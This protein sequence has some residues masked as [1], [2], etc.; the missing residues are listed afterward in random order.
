MYGVAVGKSKSAKGKPAGEGMLSVFDSLDVPAFA[1]GKGGK[2]IYANSALE[3]KLK[4]GKAA[5]GKNVADVFPFPAGAHLAEACHDALSDGKGHTAGAEKWVDSR[6]QDTWISFVVKR[7]DAG[8]NASL[9]I[10]H[11]EGANR[12]LVEQLYNKL[13]QLEQFRRLAVGREM[14]MQELKHEVEALKR[15]MEGGG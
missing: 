11:D 7:V 6:G 14:R 12:L 8:G 15:A 1:A 9:A 4:I 13:E 10:G 5:I 2:I 3:R